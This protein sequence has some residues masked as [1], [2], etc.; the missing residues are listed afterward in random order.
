M[1]DQDW[2]TDAW[3]DAMAP[4]V[5]LEVTDAQR[6]GVRTF[7]AIAKGMAEQLERVDLPDDELA[8]APV[9]TP[10]PRS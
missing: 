7:L 6:P 3:I 8:P 9:F 10:E 2:D 1:R 5:G 4:V